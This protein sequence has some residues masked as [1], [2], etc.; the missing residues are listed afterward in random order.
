KHPNSQL[1]ILIEL[2]TAP[3]PSEIGT[4]FEPEALWERA[5]AIVVLGEPTLTM[6]PLDHL[7]YLCWHY[8]FHGFS[9]LIWLYD[10]VVLLRAL[11]PDLDWDA[12][13]QAAR[14]QRLATT[15]Y[16]CLSWC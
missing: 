15:L 10:L 3:H 1:Q 9:R 5:K 13:I 11:G 12:L 6:D 14:R 2:H 8:R 16:Y 4:R 7:L